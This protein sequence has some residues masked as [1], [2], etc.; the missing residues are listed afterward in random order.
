VGGY[1]F[2]ILFCIMAYS[3]SQRLAGLGIT[4]KSS[5]FIV[6][7]RSDLLKGNQAKPV[8]VTPA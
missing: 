5:A 3:M 8:E 1:L 2:V 6:Y 7:S 4:D